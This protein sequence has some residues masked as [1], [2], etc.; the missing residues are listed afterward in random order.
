MRV[1]E[2]R[3]VFI[4][5][6]SILSKRAE[7][8]QSLHNCFIGS[9]FTEQ[10]GACLWPARNC[11]VGPVSRLHCRA[12]VSGGVTG[13]KFAERDVSFILA[14]LK[15]ISSIGIFRQEVNNGN[16]VFESGDS[17]GSL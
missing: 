16:G 11:S 5:R 8:T 15:I 7:V 9:T 3:E 2:T 4:F 17:G 10:I 1:N 14:D 12:V 6:F 13:D